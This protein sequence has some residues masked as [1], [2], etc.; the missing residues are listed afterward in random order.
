MKPVISTN[1]T[2]LPLQKNIAVTTFDAFYICLFLWS[3][4]V[5]FIPQQTF[6]NSVLHYFQL[7]NMVI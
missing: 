6:F 7:N 4:Y 5:V 3:A 2:D 1:E